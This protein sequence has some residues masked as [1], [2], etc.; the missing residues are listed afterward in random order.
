MNNATTELR[1]FLYRM[2]DFQYL[3]QGLNA[4]ARAHQ[5]GPMAGHLGAAVVAGYFVGEQRPDLDPKVYRGIEGDLE[6]VKKGESVFGSR[7]KQGESR[8]PELFRPFPRQK[9]DESLID[10]IAEALEKTLGQPRSS[11]HNVIFASIAIRALKEHPEL[12]TPAVTDG[13]R[14]L[15]LRFT[16]IHAGWGFHEKGRVSGDKVKLSPKD[17]VPEYASANGMAHAVLD[18]IIRY[19]PRYRRQGYGGLVHVC[20]HAAA[21][22]DLAQYGYPH[23]APKAIRSHR[24]HLRLWKALPNLIKKLGPGIISKHSAHSPDYWKG[25]VRYDSALLTHRVKT[26]FGFDELVAVVDDDA[27]VKQAYAKLVHLI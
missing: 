23:L 10:G 18:E 24:R 21:I 6:R 5:V 26:M 13:I 17:G 11:G 20:N 4:L 14:K 27:K 19:D 2:I 7:P 8:D 16:S 12:A 22:T 3:S 1:P 25:K 9:A 15:I